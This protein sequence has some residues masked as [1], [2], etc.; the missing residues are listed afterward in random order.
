MD[1]RLHNQV[2][3][4]IRQP[5]MQWEDIPVCMNVLFTGNSE[6]DIDIQ[7]HAMA[8]RLAIATGIEIRWHF[9]GSLQ[10]HYVSEGI[11]GVI[12]TQYDN[13]DNPYNL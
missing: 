4:K 1:T 8:K 3:F 12:I 6:R 13:P 7:I 2:S 5:N 9:T 10:G 11:M